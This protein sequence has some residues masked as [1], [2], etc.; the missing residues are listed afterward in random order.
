MVFHFL[1]VI[2][3]LS[4]KV[5]PNKLNA[6]GRTCLLWIHW[7]KRC[8]LLLLSHIFTGFPGRILMGQTI[9]LPASKQCRTTR[10]QAVRETPFC[11][12]SVLAAMLIQVE[13]MNSTST[14]FQTTICK[15]TIMLS[16]KEMVLINIIC[17]IYC[18]VLSFLCFFI[19]FLYWLI[20]CLGFGKTKSC[21]IDTI[22]LCF[23]KN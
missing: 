10:S 7:W 23:V 13:F 14:V 17:L 16:F 1:L 18:F 19:L 20:D 12:G 5:S 11:E 15:V 3:I 4:V 22:V 9:Q 21:S 6:H 8:V 2:S